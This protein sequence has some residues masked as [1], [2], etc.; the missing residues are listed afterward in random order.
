MAAGRGVLIS[1]S[2][3]LRYAHALGVLALFAGLVEAQPL[4]KIELQPALSELNLKLPVW[5]E[6]V[7]DGSGR[8]VILEQDGRI[9]IVPKDSDGKDAKEFLDIVDRKPHVDLEEGLLGLAFHPQFKT[10][11]LFYIYYNQQNPRRSVV[12]EFKTLADNPDRADT[13]SERIL[14]EV[15][16]PFENHKGGQV[17]FGPDGFLYIGLGDGG[18]GNDPFNN[19]QNTASLL[20]KILRIDV[21]TR[22]TVNFRGKPETLQYGIPTDNPLV[23]EPDLY[24]YGV[25]KEIWAYGLRNPWRFS[26]D[27]ETGE[28]WAGDVGQDQ[29]EEVDLIVKGG[30]YGW[31]VREG[32][33]HFKPGPLA[34]QYVD[35]V[36]EYPHKP[37]LLAQSRFPDHSIGASVTG[38]F[39][40]RGRKYPALRGV[41]VYADYAL[42]T[43]WGF[44]YRQGKLVEH[45]TLLE[46]SKNI[47]S[48]AQALN[49]ELYALAYD[50]HV[51]SVTVADGR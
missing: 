45:G 32:F 22:T 21:N 6:E 17:S 27:R 47:A 30:N 51:Y 31:C 4:P 29:W 25:R 15:P 8:I 42:G 5:L 7:P 48:F 43:I 38:G 36:I 12:S 14:M 23:R 3:I 40:Y 13:K 28:M 9:L 35:P 18:R 1:L 10:N 34:A 26:W 11:R 19:A 50:G 20:G 33:H 41:Y 24:E 2:R 49:G 39:V 37:E 46:Q 16:Q 44:R